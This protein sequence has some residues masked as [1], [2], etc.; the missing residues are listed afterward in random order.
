LLKTLQVEV[1]Y[2][3][4]GNRISLLSVKIWLFKNSYWCE[5][6]SLFAHDVFFAVIMAKNNVWWWWIQWWLWVAGLL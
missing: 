2:S 5:F 3:E 1:H 4:C 6:V